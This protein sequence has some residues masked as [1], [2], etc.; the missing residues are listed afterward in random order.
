[1]SQARGPQLVTRR[2]RQPGTASRTVEDLVEP[3]G[4]QRLA[5]VTDLSRHSAKINKL[6]SA[7]LLMLDLVGRRKGRFG[8]GRRLA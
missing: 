5:A 8:F 3:V 6:R 2:M 1:M 7:R 4:R